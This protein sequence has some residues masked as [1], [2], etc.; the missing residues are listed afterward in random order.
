RVVRKKIEGLRRTDHV[1]PAQSNL[2]K[3]NSQL[4]QMMMRRMSLWPRGCADFITRGL[5]NKNQVLIRMKGT[6]IRITLPKQHLSVA[7]PMQ[8]HSPL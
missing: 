6:S 1:G 4:A 2:R 5:T 3:R 7:C 8:E